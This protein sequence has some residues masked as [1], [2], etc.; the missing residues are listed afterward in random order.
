MKTAKEYIRS[1]LSDQGTLLKKFNKLL[2][3]FEEFKAIKVYKVNLEF[4][5]YTLILIIN[6]MI[7][8][9]TLEDVINCMLVKTVRGIFEGYSIIDLQISNNVLTVDYFDNNNTYSNNLSELT[10]TSI[11]YLGDL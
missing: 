11:E 1:Y 6:S 5:G 2:D 10:L 7:E 8:I 9:K 3:L 4:S